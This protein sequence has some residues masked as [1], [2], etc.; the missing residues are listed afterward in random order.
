MAHRDGEL[1]IRLIKDGA[2][3]HLQAYGYVKP[4]K[5]RIDQNVLAEKDSALELD[6]SLRYDS[7]TIYKIA[8]GKIELR[9][10]PLKNR[11]GG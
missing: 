1:R 2:L 4:S 8:P 10:S 6:V 9:C 7:D 3:P 11:A 5:S